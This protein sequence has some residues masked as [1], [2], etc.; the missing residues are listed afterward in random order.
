MSQIKVPTKFKTLYEY[1]EKPQLFYVFHGG[2]AGGKSWEIARFI[3]IEGAKR[4][5]RILCCRE[6]L[7]SIKDSVKARVRANSHKT[8]YV[9][10]R[11]FLK[12]FLIKMG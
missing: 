6:T 7:D 1:R 11:K 3:L 4:P 5:H 8:Y 2:R 12:L 9:K 10:L